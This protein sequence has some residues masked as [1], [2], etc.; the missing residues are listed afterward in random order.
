MPEFFAIKQTTS[1][2][3]N[4]PTNISVYFKLFDV[5]T[6]HLMNVETSVLS[7][8]YPNVYCGVIIILLFPLYI[9]NKKIST[10]E[11]IFKV[12]LLVLFI[13]SFN[14]NFLNF[15]WHGLH[16]P[17]S[18]PCRQSFIYIFLILTMSME[19]FKK[20]NYCTN[21]E[22]YSVF[23]GAVIFILI[24][25]QFVDF[26]FSIIYL[27]LLFLSL[28]MLIMFLY[29]NKIGRNFLITILFFSTA[30]F[31]TFINTEATSVST[32]NRQNYVSDNEYIKNLATKLENEDNDFYRI[33]K[34]YRRTKND[35]AWHNIKGVSLF[36]STAS[37]PL[38]KLF[39]KFGLMN[40]TNAYSFEGATPLIASIFNVKYLINRVEEVQKD[41]SNG[42]YIYYKPFGFRE[43]ET[44]IINEK[45]ADK[46]YIYE[47]ITNEYFLPLGFMTNLSSNMYTHSD[48]PFAVQN[49][50]VRNA[51]D[52]DSIFNM[53]SNNTNG[54]TVT[55]NS[56]K[57]Q[58]IYIYINTANVEKIHVTYG[59]GDKIITHN[60]DKKRQIVDLG[61]CK[62]NETIKVRNDEDKQ[63][64][65]SSYS[66]DE[67]T[68]KEAYKKLSSSTLSVTSFS[69]TNIKGNI[70]AN[71]SGVL[72]TS[73]PY[74]KGWTVIVNSE[75][76]EAI[77]L[78][79]AFIGVDIPSAGFYEIEFKY[80]SE[81]L[82]L[83]IY[84]SLISVTIL[85][86]IGLILWIKNKIWEV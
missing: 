36:S 32:T 44:E 60:L 61:I 80:M 28:Y 83:G 21:K 58:R 26:D 51:V 85:I 38:T 39:D 18:L 59:N 53:I 78:E 6:R 22:V 84:I 24:T 74:E 8:N 75:E 16:Y 34:S 82:K 46:T 64:N 29:R 56:D 20:S 11:K 7:G 73:I 43:N 57:T 70:N 62:Q 19:S 5:A 50:F 52:V 40:S 9:I 42:T 77:P 55:I 33:E 49:S 66:F 54:N 4:F 67:E 63:L 27:S 47:Y 3:I 45:P 37:E 69:E 2:D 72:F 48:N 76:V 41:D 14:M 31:E 30:I 81:G 35:T 68:F 79:D 23:W 25:E 12:L 71:D 13:I 17:N 65:I 1:G 15:I 10:K 86:L